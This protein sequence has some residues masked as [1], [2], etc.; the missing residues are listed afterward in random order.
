MTGG[1]GHLQSR[2]KSPHWQLRTSPVRLKDPGASADERWITFT[3][4][5]R[6]F[7]LRRRDSSCSQVHLLHASPSPI[8]SFALGVLVREA[9]ALSTNFHA[10]SIFAHTK[11]TW[12][13]LPRALKAAPHPLLS[14]TSVLPSHSPCV[15]QE[16]RTFSVRWWGSRTDFLTASG[17]WTL[18]DSPRNEKT[19]QDMLPPLPSG[20]KMQTP[21]LTSGLS[22]KQAVLLF[23]HE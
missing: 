8:T 5:L 7:L 1:T 14:A 20:A 18:R 16:K 17:S 21:G 13:L 6:M 3:K 12:I 19:A 15:T 23:R 10:N 2:A 11:G 22:N 4:G 9:Q